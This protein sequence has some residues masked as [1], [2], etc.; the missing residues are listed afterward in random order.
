M[1]IRV[2]IFTDSYTRTCT[3]VFIEL[4]RTHTHSRAHTCIYKND[5]IHASDQNT[6]HTHIV[7]RAKKK[8]QLSAVYT[9]NTTRFAS[10]HTVQI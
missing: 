7:K 1:Y 2:C 5:I 4:E 9:T 8:M 10:S 6:L 3:L